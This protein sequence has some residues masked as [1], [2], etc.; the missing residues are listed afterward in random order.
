MEEQEGLAG[1]FDN[2]QTL[3]PQDNTLNELIKNKSDK[4]L[5][6]ELLLREKNKLPPLFV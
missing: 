1:V 4:L 6:D 2:L 5:A 3:I